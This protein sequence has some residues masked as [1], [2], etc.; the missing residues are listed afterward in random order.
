MDLSERLEYDR[1]DRNEL[2]YKLEEIINNKD[3]DKLY[4]DYF[5]RFYLFSSSSKSSLFNNDELMKKMFFGFINTLFEFINLCADD[6]NILMKRKRFIE[7][8]NQIKNTHKQYN[9]TK[10]DFYAS[11]LALLMVFK[12]KRSLLT[13]RL[14]TIFE[15]VVGQ[16]CGFMADVVNDLEFD[17]TNPKGKINVCKVSSCDMIFLSKELQS[18]KQT[19]K[20]HKLNN[21]DSVNEFISK[22][23]LKFKRGSDNANNIVLR[24]RSE[25]ASLKD[26][27]DIS[28]IN[29]D[30]MNVENK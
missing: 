13:E 1:L 27:I 28:I 4:I 25:H 11:R 18:K 22:Y 2:K 16:I 26:Q 19:N 5:E 12:T 6:D 24:T 3:N 20:I 7:K 30:K 21:S 10:K 9:I 23:K 8:L 17:I 29:A 14:Q 15:L